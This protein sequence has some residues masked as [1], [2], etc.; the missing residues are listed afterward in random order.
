VTKNIQHLL[1]ED[2]IAKIIE[3][4][5]K[6]EA[7]ILKLRRILSGVL[8]MIMLFLGSTII[9]YANIYE[10]LMAAQFDGIPIL[11]SIS[12]LIPEIA[13][14]IVNMVVTYILALLVHFEKWDYASTTIMNEIARVYVA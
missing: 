9:V 13:L 5:T 12:L 14:S 2:N 4:R 11:E 7:R 1:Y 8:T 10:D 3:N 6:G